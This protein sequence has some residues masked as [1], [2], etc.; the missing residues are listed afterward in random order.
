MPR[1]FLS[2]GL[3]AAAATLL[4]DQFVKWWFLGPVDIAARGPLQIT[5][6]FEILLVWNRGISYGL[7]QQDGEAGRYFLIAVSVLAAI[8]M[9]VW[10]MRVRAMLP[11]LAL[12]LVAGGALANALD[13]LLR[14]AVVDLFHFYAGDFSW[15][16][17]NL[18]DAAIVAGV[19]GLLYDSFRVGHNG[20]KNGTKNARQ[21]DGPDGN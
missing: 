12:G 21:N 17:F 15:Y 19:A 6:F 7:F 13:R 18:A 14:G 2:A 3:A 11:A 5:P 8:L 20:A 1:P 9:L 10:L 4:V 16:V